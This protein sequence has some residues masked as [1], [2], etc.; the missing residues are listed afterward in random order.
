MLFKL[1]RITFE[2]A[3]RIFYFWYLYIKF[4]FSFKKAEKRELSIENLKNT[5]N[6]IFFNYKISETKKIISPIWMN[7]FSKHKTNT[8]RDIEKNNLNELKSTYEN[9]INSDLCLGVED[10]IDKKISLGNI[11]STLR[12][13][14]EF[15]RYIISKSIYPIFNFYQ[16]NSRFLKKIVKVNGILNNHLKRK[17]Y[18]FNSNIYNTYKID[19]LSIPSDYFDHLYFV[20]FI[21]NLIDDKN[22]K[23]IEIGGGSGFLSSLMSNIGY[24]KSIHIDIAPYLLAQNLFLNPDSEFYLSERITELNPIEADFLINQDSF[25]EIPKK[26]IEKIF[27]FINSSKVKKIFS[28]NHASDNQTQTDFRAILKKL[29]YVKRISFPNPIRRGYLIEMYEKRSN[30]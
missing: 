19:G 26:E 28:N 30:F 25:P 11:K 2:L 10:K 22:L 14:R 8:L 27:N 24:L 5:L 16:P 17:V 15:F 4:F 21:D 9:F 29:K 1:K 6:K 18:N 20:E 3:L 7:I 12:F 13:T 23:Y